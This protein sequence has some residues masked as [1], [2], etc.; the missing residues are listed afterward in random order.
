MSNPAFPKGHVTFL[1]TI[2][3]QVLSE[4]PTSID[5]RG[6]YPIFSDEQPY[7]RTLKLTTEWELLDAG[8]LK[9]ASLVLIENQKELKFSEKPGEFALVN[10]T[11]REKKTQAELIA[12]VGFSL[13]EPIPVAAAP[14]GPRDM[15][16]TPKVQATAPSPKT[17]I[18]PC[19][20]IKPGR[21]CTFEPSSLDI[22]YI[23]GT[24]PGVKVKVSVFPR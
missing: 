9:E 13:F 23:R 17:I 14:Q 3:H 18:H 22:V 1:H 5:P 6:N 15:H 21:V 24:V 12:Q 4:S 2:Y 10:P 16:S 19:M 11:S 8:W 7:V 20:V